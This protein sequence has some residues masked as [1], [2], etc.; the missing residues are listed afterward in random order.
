MTNPAKV[1]LLESPG[2]AGVYLNPIRSGT[3]TLPEAIA[4]QGYDVEQ[5]LNEIEATNNVLDAK[6]IILD[7]DPRRVNDKGAV[8]P[9]P[10]NAVTN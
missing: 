8:Q 3:L 2:R 1:E 6:G 9:S 10:E 5:Q 4:Q 7:C